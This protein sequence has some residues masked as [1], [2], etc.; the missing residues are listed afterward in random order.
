[1]GDDLLTFAETPREISILDPEGNPLL[2]GGQTHLRCVKVKE[3][4]H[5]SDGS[6]H[7]PSAARS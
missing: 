2:S 6:I 5:R 7:I 3:L 4:S 1:M